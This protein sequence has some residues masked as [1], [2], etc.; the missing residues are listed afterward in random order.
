ME[1]LFTFVKRLRLF[2]RTE[3]VKLPRVNGTS[4]LN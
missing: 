2:S 3:A 4:V 1:L